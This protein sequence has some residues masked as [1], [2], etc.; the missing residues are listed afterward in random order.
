MQV[1]KMSNKRLDYFVQK[2]NKLHALIMIWSDD[3]LKIFNGS[4]LSIIY[5]IHC[6]IQNSLY[7]DII[8]NRTKTYE[9]CMI[10]SLSHNFW[11]FLAYVIRCS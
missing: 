5:Y 10:E 11:R 2:S 8:Y 9:R 6:D 1:H 3:C 7:V 4:F